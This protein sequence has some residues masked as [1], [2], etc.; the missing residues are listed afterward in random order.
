VSLAKRPLEPQICLGAARQALDSRYR[1]AVNARV[2]I[3]L[4]SF[5]GLANAL[6]AASC[7]PTCPG[8]EPNCGTANASTAGAA[9][10]AGAESTASCTQLTSLKTCMKAFCA[11]APLTNPFCNCYKKGFDLDV[12]NCPACVDFD[13]KKF[14]DDQKASGASYD[15]SSATGAIGTACVGVE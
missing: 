9:G 5:L 7:G 4:A 3:F 6:S 11:S 10:A 1:P 8:N 14:C 15:C 2:S 13:A 12:A